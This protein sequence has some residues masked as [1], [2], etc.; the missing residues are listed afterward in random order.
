[1]GLSDLAEFFSVIFISYKIYI[2]LVMF[3]IITTRVALEIKV[4]SSFFSEERTN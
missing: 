3:N 2:F 1:M 4:I